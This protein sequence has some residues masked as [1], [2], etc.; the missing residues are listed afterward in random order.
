M[1]NFQ[2]KI[3][4]EK[5]STSKPS[6]L[7][8]NYI[9]ESDDENYFEI[10]KNEKYKDK[11]KTLV[12]SDFELPKMINKNITLISK[13]DNFKTITVD[14]S[15]KYY[16][17]RNNNDNLP[18]FIVFNS[19]VVSRHHAEIY[20]ENDNLYIIDTGSNGGTYVNNERI[21]NQGCKSE[22]IKLNSGDI[23]QLGQDY[24]ENDKNKQFDESIYKCV[25][26][27]ILIPKND[28][29]DENESI[30]SI[31]DN[32]ISRAQSDSN[33]NSKRTSIEQNNYNNIIN[34][35]NFKMKK[36]ITK[37]L[38]DSK[39]I[40]ESTKYQLE[41]Y[42]KTKD[43]N[44]KESNINIHLLDNL[45]EK[46]CLQ[47][48]FVIY[49]DRKKINRIQILNEN[50]ESIFE[51]TLKDWLNKRWKYNEENKGKIHI[52]D[53][54]EE[55]SPTSQIKISKIGKLTTIVTED[56]QL[57]TIE[58]I[59]EMKYNII[60]PSETSPQF[61]ITGDFEQHNW[62]CITKF[63]DSR[64]QRCIGE[65]KG[66]QLVEKTMKARKWVVSVQLET[67]NYSQLLLSAATFIIAS[68]GPYY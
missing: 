45:K 52:I 60:T 27:E 9:N 57:G 62:L 6:R 20:M 8:E 13:C 10:S 59:S 54:R 66:K 7:I 49:S 42:E 64:K 47:F 28:N 22:P 14:L 16:M 32:E 26:F 63:K 55:Y 43:I 50:T 17:G 24:Y 46:I 40:V 48:F 41:L 3:L 18:N 68:T 39:L 51:I 44:N 36:E 67:G 12:L 56:Y 30:Y 1:E 2:L 35:N 21:N 19:L 11:N 15:N 4:S 65:G 33:I 38:Y 5:E 37:E 31:N 58:K 29:S 61:C 53:K 23:V 25:I 34:N